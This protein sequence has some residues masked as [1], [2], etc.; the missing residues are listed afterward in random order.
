MRS[1]DRTL[2]FMRPLS[3]RLLHREHNSPWGSSSAFRKV[4]WKACDRNDNSWKI[5]PQHTEL[6]QKLFQRY[7]VVRREACRLFLSNWISTFPSSSLLLRILACNENKKEEKHHPCILG[8]FNG[9]SDAPHHS[10][11][12][13]DAPYH[14]NGVSDAPHHSNEVSDA[15]HHSNWVSDAPYH[16][17]GISDALYF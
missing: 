8:L 11:G 9:V 7:P 16:S 3:E 4:A 6:S 17:N 13:S 10:N 5:L 2:V 12:V 1:D 14:S 15:P